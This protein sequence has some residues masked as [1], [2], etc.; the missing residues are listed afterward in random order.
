MNESVVT[1]DFKTT[2]FWWDAAPPRE[3]VTPLLPSEVDVAIVGS[4]YTGLSAAL[5][6]A[7]AGSRVHVFDAEHAG[8]GAST[9]NAGF[10]GSQLYSKLS[11]LIGR[12]G[13]ERGCALAR[14][15]VQA[16]RYLV[17]FIEHE[18]IACHFTYCGRFIGAHSKQSYE[19]LGRESEVLLRQ[20]SVE[21][22]LV[23]RTSQRREIGSDYFH[24][25]LVLPLSGALHPGHYHAGLLDR[26]LTAGV[27]VHPRTAVTTITRGA[28]AS[29]EVSSARGIVRA[30]HAIVATNGYTGASLPWLQRRLIGIHAGL[31]VTEPLDPALVR[32]VLPSARTF[33]D[34]RMN[35]ISIRVM[36]DGKRL[37]FTAARG[38]F[39]ND[40]V[41]KA[42]E[43]RRH[44]AKS[45]PALGKVHFS[46]YWTGQM[47]F[48]FDK[49]P[50][51]GEHDGVL[52]AAGYCGVG[53]P[54]ATWLGYKLALRVLGDAD[55]VTVF[56]SR[57]FPTRPFYRGRAWFLAPVLGWYALKDALESRGAN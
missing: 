57:R 17:D 56:D 9:R 7:R 2:P 11:A 44:V 42:A 16:H 15:A 53:M 33:I 6:L 25:G 14:E 20:L 27:V 34:T 4:G 10:V 40:H 32:E 55:A 49:L 37:Q 47:G 1:D 19:A 41:A 48:T 54:M 51:I 23:P 3:L 12:F 24:G 45:V 39:V 21:S 43:V 22:E 29:F 5:T 18:Q 8:Y 50:H 35:P 38:L 30:R 31:G 26:A 36:P 46:H 13:I 52:Y 28:T